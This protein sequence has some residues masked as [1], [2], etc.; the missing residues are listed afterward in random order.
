MRFI[1]HISKYIVFFLTNSANIYFVYIT[2]FLNFQILTEKNCIYKISYNN[3]EKENVREL[4]YR[5]AN[6]K[7]NECV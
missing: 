6:F 7:E 1:K 4:F 3:W 5:S 2:Q